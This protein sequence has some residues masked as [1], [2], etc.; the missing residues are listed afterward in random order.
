MNP[1]WNR[2]TCLL[3]IILSSVLHMQ[4]VRAI[5]YVSKATS[6]TGIADTLEDTFLKQLFHAQVFR[7]LPKEKI[8]CEL[9]AIRIQCTV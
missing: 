3:L 6:K 9:S 7:I 4:L 8:N 5:Y 1:D 2:D